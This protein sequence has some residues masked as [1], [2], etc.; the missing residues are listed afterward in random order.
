MILGVTFE[1]LTLA[2]MKNGF[3]TAFSLLLSL[4]GFAQPAQPPASE[5]YLFDLSVKKGKIAIS[6]PVNITNHKGYDNQPF[7][8]PGESL[9]Y[10]SSFNDDGRADIRSY[11]YKTKTTQNITQTNEKEYSPS[12][13]LDGHSISCIIQRDNGAQD[14]GK[15]PITGGEATVIIDNMTI[16][17]HVWADNSHLG[18]FVLGDPNTLHYLR[19]PTKKDTVIA[20]N[21][22]RSLHKIPGQNGF[23]FIQKVT[24]TE[25]LIK[26]FDTHTMKITNIGP[27]IPGSQD[28]AWLPDGKILMSNGLKV[29]YMDPAD[30]P[31]WNEIN[32]SGDTLK[33]ISRMAVSADG[34]KLALVALE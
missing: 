30:G 11:N 12:V 33:G 32:I 28:L 13:T 10:Y 27:T 6:N 14:L 22:G 16:G 19:L 4:Y 3:L 2:P 25:W 34:K 21:I 1:T 7:F 15:Y 9:I 31:S 20:Q 26:R 29:F 24:D 17:Y 23:S 18:L 5:I 8:H